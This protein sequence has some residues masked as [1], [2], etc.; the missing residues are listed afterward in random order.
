MKR[1][2]LIVLLISGLWGYGGLFSSVR[3]PRLKFEPMEFQ[4]ISIAEGL[5][6]GVVPCIFQDSKGFM[7][8]GTEAGVNRY[9]GDK[10]T[11]YSH[12]PGDPSSLS[13]DIVDCIC[14]D[15]EKN[16]W[17]G[18]L[19]GLNKL[20][21]ENGTF[22]RYLHDPNNPNSLSND[23]IGSLYCDPLGIL[24][25][26]TRGGVNTLDP[27]TGTFSCFK[28]DPLDPG[29]ISSDYIFTISEEKNGTLWIGTL[30]GLNR[31]SRETGAFTVYRFNPNAGAIN[32]ARR[33]SIDES[34]IIWIGTNNG[35]YKFH[36]P[37]GK[38]T[39]YKIKA[40][41][42]RRELDAFT[43][44]IL[45]LY[46]DR[47]HV[48][49]VGTPVDGLQLFD[50]KTEQFHAYL[51]NPGDP[52]SLSNNSVLSIFEDRSGLIW[53]GTYG[54]GIN[55]YDREKEKFTY[56]PCNIWGSRH[57]YNLVYSFLEDRSG[58]LWIGIEL[59][60]LVKYDK[61]TGTFTGYDIHPPHRQVMGYSQVYSI[62]EDGAG[63]LWLGT[64]GYGLARFDPKTG[65]IV[66]FSNEPG[67][68]NSLSHNRVRSIASRQEGILWIGTV[69][70]GIDRFDSQKGTFTH[71]RNDP[72]K[73]T[74]LSDDRVNTLYFDRTGTMWVGTFGGL[75]RFNPGTGTFTRYQPDASRPNALSHDQVF[76]ICED[77]LRKDVLWIG[78]WKGGL[79]RIDRSRNT[80]TAFTT[81]DGLPNNCIYGILEDDRGNLWL[82]TTKGI[83]R[84]NPSTGQAINYEPRDG[85][86]DYEFNFGAYYKNRS[87]EMFF[88]GSKGFNRFHPRDIIDNPHVPSISFTGFETIDT[89]DFPGKKPP[90][91]KDLSET[92]EISLSYKDNIFSL[93]FAALDFTNPA[94]NQYMYKL[95]GFDDRWISLGNRHRVTFTNLDPGEYILRVRGSNNDGVWNNEGTWIKI[96]V[97]PPYWR[98]WWFRGVMVLLVAAL[99]FLWHH[100]RLKHLTLKLK[101]REE[102]GRLFSRHNIS[103]R[104]QEII[105]YI[106]KGKSN[107]EIEDE[108]YI[109][110]KTVK[111]HIYNIYQK[112]GVKNRLELIN[113][114][115]KS[116]EK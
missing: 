101:T 91:P 89:P 77:H 93:E 69:G 111:S 58:V 74:T 67:N 11:V 86:Q 19:K 56:Y 113:V 22:T 18:T 12:I 27:K 21:K 87:G 43:N 107:K 35:L 9:D 116:L 45:A 105:S 10:F 59:G 88:G 29:S 41:N 73:N 90:L 110:L 97:K 33:I 64:K 47:D 2:T 61:N 42:P 51:N 36:P 38:F 92:R 15:H 100:S 106:L 53:I 44:S 23:Y 71:Y 39:A 75:D 83:C 76:S 26:G 104:E 1:F 24:W 14:E 37:T 63:M 54:G 96:R 48:L 99:A 40:E 85:L 94:K 72:Q 115:Q 68:P 102:M 66:W 17:F 6:Q 79:H 108:L 70:G 103:S 82:S 20:N 30:D 34:G 60:G 65:K 95:E 50:P 114:L 78:T 98:T 28:H 13:H 81:R 49:W 8:F 109:S 25:I 80:F 62:Y 4:H 112:I 57:P 16:L 52:Y 3:N 5:S 7:W 32:G 55:K 46:S 31:F 84:F